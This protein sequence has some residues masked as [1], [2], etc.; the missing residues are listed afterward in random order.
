MKIYKGFRYRIYPT[1]DQAARFCE[2]ENTLRFLWNLALEQRLQCLARPGHHRV[3]IT[4]FDQSKELTDI[5]KEADWIADVPRDVSTQ[6]LIELDKAWQRF[7]KGISKQPR[8]KKRLRGAIGICETK[9]KAWRIDGNT[10]R[11]PKVGNVKM[12]LHRPLEGKPKTCTIRRDGDQWFVGISC[13]VEIPNPVPSGKPAIGLDLGVVN[14][15]AGSDGTLVKN[16]R[17]S[18]KSKRQLRNA[19]NIVARRRKGSNNQI[20]AKVRVARLHRKIRRQ[21]EHVL[22]VES[23]RITKSHGCAIVEKLNIVNMSASAKGTLDEP[24]RNVKQ[25]SGLNRAIL[26]SGWHSFVSK[27]KYKMEWSGGAVVEVAA[28]YSSQTCNICGAV[29]KNNRVSQSRFCCILCGHEEHADINAAKV[30]LSRGSHG[31]AVC[32]GSAVRRPVKQK[33]RVVRRGHR[34]K[35][36]PGISL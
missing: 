4:A 36:Y 31:A 27:L 9:P 23:H 13:E 24:G 35:N 28:A 16:H 20:K 19:Q 33:L 22:H 10:L 6:M 26:D 34:S 15:I 8:W 29:D 18:E 1:Q 5:R 12:R 17:F 30:L 3:F 32:G 21:R 25:K 14:L 7:F 11:F 2:W